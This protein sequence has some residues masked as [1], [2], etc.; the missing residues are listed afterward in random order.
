[1]AKIEYGIKRVRSGEITITGLDVNTAKGWVEAFEKNYGEP[2]SFIIVYRA[3][4]SWQE[5]KE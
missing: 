5:F 1:M 2:D 3:I 4:S